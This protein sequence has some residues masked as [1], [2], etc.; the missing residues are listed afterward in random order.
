MDPRGYIKHI[1]RR[2]ITLI[3]ILVYVLEA[4]SKKAVKSIYKPRN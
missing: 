2:R 4:D 1:K 3:C